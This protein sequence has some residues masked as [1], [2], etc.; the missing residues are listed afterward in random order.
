MLF[1]V[2][3]YGVKLRSAA[4]SDNCGN[5]GVVYDCCGISLS[6]TDLRN[7][8]FFGLFIYVSDMQA[9]GSSFMAYEQSVFPFVHLTNHTVSTV[10]L[11]G[12]FEK[13]IKTIKRTIKAEL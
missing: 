7:A 3:S 11:L 6:Q 13:T 2:K 12:S 10:V 8:Q 1:I 5:L 9:G 4:L